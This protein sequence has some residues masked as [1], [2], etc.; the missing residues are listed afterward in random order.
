MTTNTQRILVVGATGNQGSAVVQH[1]LKNGWPVRALTR[2]ATSDKAKN[3]TSVGAEVVQGDLNDRAS[4]D[5]VLQGV[6]GVFG[7]LNFGLPGVGPEGE[8]RQGT[9]L[10]DAAK[11]SGVQHFVFSSVGGAERHSGI[12]H[13]ESKWQV[14]QHIREL[15]LPS[16]M[17][18]PVAFMDNYTF[19]RPMILNGIFPSFG[20]RPDKTMQLVTIADV[21][22]FAFLAFA[23]PERYLGAALEIA[24]DE[25]TSSQTAAV[26]SRVIGRPVYVQN[27]AVE[28]LNEQDAM[29]RWFNEH[30]YAANIPALRELHPEL[31]TLEAWVRKT[32][33]ENAEPVP[34]P[35]ESEG[36]G[37]TA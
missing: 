13:F 8:V 21:A 6:Y 11:A 23:N 16:T 25:L 37:Q 10:A 31:L 17:L 36:P 15:G 33:W 1:L 26:F 20:L 2:D 7:V 32:G 30:G 3:L 24:G 35:A 28:G 22:A 12:P 9:A 4:L 18:R 19:L 27:S 29:L 34:L 5:A 14:E